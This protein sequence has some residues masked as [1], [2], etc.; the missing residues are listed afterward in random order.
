MNTAKSK[1]NISTSTLCC[2]VF[3][4]NL[5]YALGGGIRSN[6]GIMLGGISITATGSYTTIWFVS[7]ILALLAGCACF[8]VKESNSQP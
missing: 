8:M 7:G 4:A 2:I 3:A 5:F 1:I 6:Y